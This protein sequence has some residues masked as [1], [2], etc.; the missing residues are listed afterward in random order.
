M[1][2]AWA[3]ARLLAGPAPRARL[4]GDRVAPRGQL[5][6]QEPRD[7]VPTTTP[8]AG[9]LAAPLRRLGHPSPVRR[10][11]RGA[12]REAARAVG[13]AAGRKPPERAARVC[14]QPSVRGA[15]VAADDRM[16]AVPWWPPQG[17]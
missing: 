14:D 9:R 1:Q 6:P 2:R 8:S 12:A 10:A 17:A 7:S 16:A 4:V 3:D 15:A 5:G 11:E 13:G